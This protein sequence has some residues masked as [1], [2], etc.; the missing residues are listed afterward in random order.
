MSQQ[1]S[2]AETAT[3][4]PYWEEPAVELS[5][6]SVVFGHTTALRD[7]SVS[8]LKGKTTAVIGPAGSGKSTLLRAAAGIIPIDAGEVRHFSSPIDSLNRREAAAHKR[9]IGFVFQDAALWQNMSIRRNLAL[10]LEFHYPNIS[11]A[12]VDAKT[13]EAL[14]RVRFRGNPDLRPATLSA[15]QAKLVA[16]ARATILDPEILFLDEPTTFLDENAYRNVVELLEVMRRNGRT[17]IMVTHNSEVTHRIADRIVLVDEGTVE[18]TGRTRQIL[19]ASD[20][21]TQ[22]LLHAAVFSELEDAPD[23]PA[24]GFSQADDATTD[25]NPVRPA[26][27]SESSQQASC[28]TPEHLPKEAANDGGG[29]R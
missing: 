15:G 29:P 21:R 24:E 6:V 7:V 5:S 26:S 10:P 16:F 11:Q 19:E 2:S 25:Q 22:Q 27:R 28:S 18:S 20:E 3:T 14:R 17:L 12:D 9:L 4:P 13:D 8:F 1:V 23:A